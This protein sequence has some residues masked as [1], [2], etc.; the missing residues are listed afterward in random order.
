MAAVPFFPFLLAHRVGG[1]AIPEGGSYPNRGL[2]VN[3]VL[4]QIAKES[5][6]VAACTV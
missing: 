6:K 4:N 2:A 3:L 1:R 5:S